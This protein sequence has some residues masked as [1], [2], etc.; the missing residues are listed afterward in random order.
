VI[1]KRDTGDKK[2]REMKAVVCK[3]ATF[4]TS[5]VKVITTVVGNKWR[6]T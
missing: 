2:K 6:E 5:T 4:M 1:K 3:V